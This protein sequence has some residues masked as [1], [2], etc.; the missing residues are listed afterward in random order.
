MKRSAK[1]LIGL[2]LFILF[3]SVYFIYLN[4]EKDSEN[5]IKTFK[6]DNLTFNY[7][8]SWKDFT[9]NLSKKSPNLDKEYFAAVGNNKTA[10]FNGMEKPT[11]VLII[12]KTTHTLTN[13]EN[14]TYPEG[15][16]SEMLI[17]SWVNNTKML[18]SYPDRT[19]ETYF[20]FLSI[21]RPAGYGN[22]NFS[23]RNLTIDGIKAYE[24]T[25]KGFNRASNKVEYTRIVAFEKRD[26]S[27]KKEVFY[28]ITCTAQDPDIEKSIKTF[29]M[30]IDSLQINGM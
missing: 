15:N 27:K 14:F 2:I 22:V 11:M 20:G 30:I 25:F 1:P 7:P 4:Q 17:Q 8:G 18:E 13:G 23:T 6:K 12:D 16:M 28:V 24:F 26:T 5:T 9:D 10:D 19:Q 3:F 21:M 29:D